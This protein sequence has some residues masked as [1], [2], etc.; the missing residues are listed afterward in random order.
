MAPL[1]LDRGFVLEGAGGDLVVDAQAWPLS[2]VVIDSRKA[3]PGS[4]FVALPGARTDGHEHVADAVRRGARCLLVRRDRVELVRSRLAAW[5]APVAGAAVAV[6][7]VQDTL[8]GLHGLAARHLAGLTGMT[9]IGVTGSSGKTTTKEAIGAILSET[10]STAI[11]EG[12]LNSESGLPL[13]LLA[14]GPGHRY[15]VFELAIDHPGEMDRLAGLL[16]PDLAV[17]TNIGSAHSEQ[18]SSREG[19]AAEK[20]R[21]FSRFAGSETAFVWEDDDYVQFLT[22]GVNGAVVTFGERTTRGYRGSV[23][24]GLDGTAIDW[25]GLR[26][27]FPLFGRHNLLNALAAATVA[28]AAGAGAGAIKAGLEKVKPLFGRSQVMRGEI[29]LLVDCYNSN[30]E[31]LD[32][33]LRFVGRVPWKGRKVAVL[34]S[35]LEL[36]AGSEAAHAQAGRLACEAGVD[37]IYLFGEE[38]RAGREACRALCPQRLALWTADIGRLTE[39]LGSELEAGDLVLIKGS[40]GMAMERLLEPLS[41]RAA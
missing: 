17:I 29:T 24:L 31:S 30:P 39:A 2:S 33:V 38:I 41:R 32:A 27:H 3:G 9:R 1:S 28:G 5:G 14:A 7:A 37:R 6:V 13:A 26:V 16:R 35:M 34:G 22:S 40:R 11:S 4:L 36:G 23:D 20:K 8:A 10:A 12:N 25:E 19:I 21:I 15:G 18:L